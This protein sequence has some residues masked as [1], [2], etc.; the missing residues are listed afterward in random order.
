[1]KVAV[2]G[3]G[4]GGL[5]ASWR[6]GARHEVTVFERHAS[7]GMAV[8]G[9]RIG[10]GP[11][12]PR[13]DVPLRVFYPGYY[14]QLTALYRETGVDTEPVDYSTTFTDPAGRVF[15]GYRNLRAGP[16]TLPVPAGRRVLRR[17]GLRILRDFLRFRRRGL[18][19]TA[20]RT[21]GAL[22]EDERYSPEF[23]RDFLLPAFATICT[24]TYDNVL[25]F[26]ADHVVEY[27]SRGVLLT[28]VRRA[29]GG[30]DEVV[31]R[32]AGRARLRC[33]VDLRAIRRG[34]GCVELV[35]DGATERFDHVVVATQA[36]H[37]LRLLADASATER[38]TLEAVRYDSVEVVTH[39][40]EAL[41]PP[42]RADWAPVN[43]L[44]SPAHDRPMSTIWMNAVQ[45]ALR[46]AAPVFQTVHPLVEP[47]ASKVLARHRFER[48]VVDVAS[49]QALDD[50]A[51]L[52]RERDRRVWF[53]GSYARPGIPLLESA[54]A[55]SEALLAALSR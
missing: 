45:S 32:L 31:R 44:V 19:G 43:L 47:A 50:L 10:D 9:V 21:I 12:A 14:P 28:S 1:M 49:R 3:A 7:P 26:P 24:C 11:D 34:E 6:L 39:T 51:A 20:G 36:N 2:V 55:S 15:F 23:V 18:G 16:F 29:R 52:H 17:R 42:Q 8:H 30:A 25:T 46:N 48:S 13:V 37:A 54:V 53:C 5:A 33:G 40:D 4:I 38:R 35:V 27:L 41:L 22:L